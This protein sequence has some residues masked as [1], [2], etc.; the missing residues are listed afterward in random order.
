MKPK[1]NTEVDAE[2]FKLLRQ[3]KFS[4]GLMRELSDDMIGRAFPKVKGQKQKEEG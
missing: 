4:G 3:G 2:D 1:K